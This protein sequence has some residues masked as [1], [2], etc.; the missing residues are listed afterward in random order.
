[1]RP[2]RYPSLE[3]RLLANSV[4]DPSSECWWWLGRLNRQAYGLINLY[5]D[6][7]TRTFRV[8]RVAYEEW[9]GPIPPEHTIDHICEVS[10]CINPAHLQPLLNVDNCNLKG[11]HR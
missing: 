4:L 9:V 10:W 1:M 8:H 11:R 6:G 5:I 2:W 7:R 3:A